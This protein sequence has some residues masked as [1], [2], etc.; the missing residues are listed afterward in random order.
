MAGDRDVVVPLSIY[1]VVVVFSTLI[2]TAGVVGGFMTLDAA[3]KR[4]TATASDIDPLLALLGVGLL[5]C[6]AAVFAFAARFRAPGMGTDKDEE[7]E[8]DRNG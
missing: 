5:A 2:A 1:K 6:G 8:P 3:T 7:A 4:A